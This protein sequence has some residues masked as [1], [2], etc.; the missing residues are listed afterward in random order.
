M[1]MTPKLLNDGPKPDTVPTRRS[2]LS[3]LK[4]WEDQDSWREFFDTYWK[5][6]YSVAV[7]SGLSDQEAEDVVQETVLTV[8]K[9]MGAIP[10]R[11][12]G[13]FLQRLAIACDAVSHPGPTSQ[14]P[15]R[16]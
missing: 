7:K 5:L 14:T 13:L 1:V 6:I 12:G 16:H 15:A 3:R 8:A 11:S 4:R 2:L 9:K 10:I